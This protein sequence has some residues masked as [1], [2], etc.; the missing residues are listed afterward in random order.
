VSVRAAEALAEAWPTE[1]A[2][3][4]VDWRLALG[5]HG[6][7]TL[8]VVH[9]GPP[10]GAAAT[11]VL[12]KHLESTLRTTLRLIEHQLPTDPVVCEPPVD[13]G[14][15]DEIA[16]LLGEV[17]ASSGLYACATLPSE[18]SD[19]DAGPEAGPGAEPEAVS[20]HL[21]RLLAA[22]HERV[23]VAAASGRS[24]S[25]AVRLEP[26]TEAGAGDGGSEQ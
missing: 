21:D 20:A 1:A 7:A 6:E 19:V 17:V 3:K 16:R 13:A 10:L 11:E 22:P 9:L 2:G 24:W 26:C 4:L 8:E 5:G 25:L 18:P 12:T 15:V 14:C 23:D